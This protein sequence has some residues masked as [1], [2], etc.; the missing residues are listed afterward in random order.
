[1][2]R[3]RNAN[4]SSPRVN[5][6]K[7]KRRQRRRKRLRRKQTK[8]PRRQKRHSATPRGARRLRPWRKSGR[9]KLLLQQRRCMFAGK[10]SFKKSHQMCRKQRG[11]GR[12]L[13]WHRLS[14]QP[15]RCRLRRMAA[16][17][18]NPSRNRGNS[19]ACITTAATSRKILASPT[20]RILQISIQKLLPRC[21]FTRP[22]EN[23]H[24]VLAW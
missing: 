14:C 18:C 12:M 2:R 13:R 7:L 19:S 10:L 3:W 24:K 15:C 8:R 1:M 20:R 11:Q 23:F 17:E 21:I 22:C 6:N 9:P 4:G 5:S 16:Q